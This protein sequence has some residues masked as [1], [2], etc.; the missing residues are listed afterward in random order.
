MTDSAP[1]E[2]SD[3]I[4]KPESSDTMRPQ[5]KE[6]L[7]EKSKSKERN[8][9]RTPKKYPPGSADDIEETESL[10]RKANSTEDD[11]DNALPPPEAG[12]VRLVQTKRH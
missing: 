1:S 2:W 5:S 4:L 10:W 7:G 3:E 11:S 12:S 9:P 8:R 6:G